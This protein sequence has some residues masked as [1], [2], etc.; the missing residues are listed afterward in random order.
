MPTQTATSTVTLV[1]NKPPVPVSDSSTLLEEQSVRIA[2]LLNDTD[3][4]DDP[5]T[6]LSVGTAGHGSATIVG[7]QVQY[8]PVKD[9][10]GTDTFTYTIFDGHTEATS[11]VLLTILPVNDPPVANTD[12]IDT[13]EDSVAQFNAL[14]NDTDVDLDALSIRS[15]SQAA[16][17]IVALE[18]TT[19]VYKPTLNYNGADSFTYIVTDGSAEATA[20]V[21][22]QIAAVNDPPSAILDNATVAEDQSVAVALLENDRDVEGDS[23]TI[24]AAT[25]P[26]SGTVTISADRMTVLYTPNSNFNGT[27]EFSYTITD[28]S[29][30]AQGVVRVLVTAVND[31]PVAI[32]DTIGTDEDT[33]VVVDVTANDSDVDGDTLLV[34]AFEQ[35]QNGVVSADGNRLLY[36]PN[37]DFFGSDQFKYTI[38]D[39]KESSSATVAV[40][41]SSV[42]DSPLARDDAATVAEDGSVVISVLGNDSD[43]EGQ[44]LSIAQVSTAQNGVVAIEGNNVRYTPKQNFNGT[45]QFTYTLLGGAEPATVTI[46]VTPVDDPPTA[47]PDSASTTEDTPVTISVLDNDTDIDSTL[48]ISGV[49]EPQ[50]GTATVE[51]NTVRY[52]P[53]RNFNGSDQF[54]YTLLGAVDPVAVTI[55][56]TPV[57]DPPKAKDDNSSTNMNE[58]IVIEVLS[59]DVDVDSENLTISIVNQ[60]ANGSAVISN[61][62]IIYTPNDGYFTREGDQPEQFVYRLSD[63]EKTDDATV[64]ITV[65]NRPPMAVDDSAT[66]DANQAV[67]IAVLENDSDPDGT[68]VTIA[69]IGAAGNGTTRIEG[70]TIVYLANPGFTGSDS[71]TYVVSDGANQ[72]EAVVTVEVS[73]SAP[74]AQDD[75][76]TTIQGQ[77][78]AISPLVNDSDSNGDSLT[79]VGISQPQNGTAVRSD[80]VITYTPNIS[81]TSGNDS[82]TYI[83]SDGIYTTTATVHVTVNA[84]SA[85]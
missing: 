39:G 71:F 41:I 27:D 49:A 47:A 33:P 75:A 70:A 60:P 57:N 72:A 4:E 10:H 37:K 61:T 24:V 35:G 62:L 58:T 50:H 66:T 65:I 23:L 31:A 78:V 43:P 82:F 81:F 68:A 59:N 38:S 48:Q 44:P 51:G 54:T 14:A 83:V 46:T 9:Y 26:R 56:V 74:D 16:H 20:Q 34:T 1:G 52:T 17:G 45:D 2:V 69:G 21:N 6:I 63:G 11:N 40:T 73:N 30:T 22:I 36:M 29:L 42:D 55:T 79:L 12:S 53:K 32:N 85:P 15:F 18:G 19:F 67:K 84:Q 76:A 64:R 28:G 25:N 5:L 3:P 8:V 80:S 7:N 77:A 13:S